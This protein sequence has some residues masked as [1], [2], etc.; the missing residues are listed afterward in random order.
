MTAALEWPFLTCKAS[1]DSVV[2]RPE[3]ENRII[4][5]LHPMH[6]ASSHLFKMVSTVAAA[7]EE[8]HVIPDGLEDLLAIGY[9]AEEEPCTGCLPS[10]LCS[11]ALAHMLHIAVC[12]T[13]DPGSPCLQDHFIFLIGS[14]YVVQTGVE[15]SGPPASAS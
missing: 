4:W 1:V 5:T 14:H 7:E 9:R 13:R 3:P 15:L 12:V 11:A 10:Q 6:G 8:A 2:A